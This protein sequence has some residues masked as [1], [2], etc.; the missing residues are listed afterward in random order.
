VVF[1]RLY[2]PV[3]LSTNH[4]FKEHLVPLT[5]LGVESYIYYALASFNLTFNML[6]GK[7]E[8][9]VIDPTGNVVVDEQISE[10]TVYALKAIDYQEKEKIEFYSERAKYKMRV[11]AIDEAEFYVE[12]NRLHTTERLF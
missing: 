9:T 1:L 5:P 11:G 7:I 3:P 8:V 10:K 12:V 4:I 6:S 2:D